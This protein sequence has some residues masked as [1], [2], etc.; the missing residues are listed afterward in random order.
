MARLGTC[1]AP[2]LVEALAHRNGGCGS[3]PSRPGQD[4]IARRG[5]SAAALL[6]NDRDSSLR[7]DAVRELGDIGDDARAWSFCSQ[8]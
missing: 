3:M 2:V 5:R 7:E 6:F 8:R 4:E 1:G